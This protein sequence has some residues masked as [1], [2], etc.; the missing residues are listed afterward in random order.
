ME[1]ILCLHQYLK[2]TF[3]L[4]G[5]NLSYQSDSE[6]LER[7]SQTRDN[8]HLGILLQRYTY[9][10]LG[11][12]MKYLKNEEEAKDAVQQVFLKVIHELPRYKVEYFKSWIYTIARNHCLMQLR[13]K[14]KQT[15][16]INEKIVAAEESLTSKEQL[17]QQ[18]LQLNQ[19][20]RA[21]EQLNEEQKLCVTLFYLKKQTYQQIAES[22][23]FTLMQVKSFIQNGKRNLKLQLLK[24]QDH[25]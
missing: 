4:S 9:L 8:E 12:C 10:L 24:M 6:L 14:G 16:P 15:S 5:E 18:D 20:N 11:V 21:L 23:G 1:F 2:T 3:S 7:F 17:L 22:S 13:N 19:L 25:E